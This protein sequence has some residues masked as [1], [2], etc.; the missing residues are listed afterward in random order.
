MLQVHKEATSAVQAGRGRV[1]M[2]ICEYLDCKVY[3]NTPSI[4]MTKTYHCGVRG[5]DTKVSN[6]CCWACRKMRCTYR[7]VSFE[8]T[9]IRKRTLMLA[10][11]EPDTR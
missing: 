2:N 11:L 3:K 8:P 10:K 7:T 9:N 6:I 5:G 1:W 4:Q